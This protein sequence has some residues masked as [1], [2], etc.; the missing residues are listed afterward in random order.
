MLQCDTAQPFCGQCRRTGRLCSGYRQLD[1]LRVL[2]QTSDVVS[3]CTK[4]RQQTLTDSTCRRRFV[5][6]W[7]PDCD[8]SSDSAHSPLSVAYGPTF[9]LVGTA[10]NVFFAQYV[11]ITSGHNKTEF[12]FVKTV[13]AG[14]SADEMLADIIAALGMLFL[15]RKNGDQSVKLAATHKY[16]RALGLTQAALEDAERVKSDET[17]ATVS[18]LAL[19]EVNAFNVI[20]SIR[21]TSASRS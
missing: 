4:R 5:R 13:Y 7:R 3:R 15:A 2:E 17:I 10:H 18:L 8:V 16:A 9:V 12:D 1:V 14:A 19:H 20:D 11:N 6:L 21:L